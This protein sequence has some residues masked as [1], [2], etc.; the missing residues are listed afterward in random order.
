MTVNVRVLHVFSE[1]TRR[2]ACREFVWLGLHT[3]FWSF[4]LISR[5]SGNSS[6]FQGCISVFLDWRTSLVTHAYGPQKLSFQGSRWMGPWQSVSSWAL[7]SGIQVDL[8]MIRFWVCAKIWGKY[9]AGWF[10]VIFTAEAKWLQGKD[11]RI[12]RWGMW[13]GNVSCSAVTRLLL[14]S[15]FLLK[16]GKKLLL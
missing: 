1:Q 6:N 4:H 5:A 10:P 7:G 16:T 14:L 12:E 8:S 11:L 3:G 2:N 9:L 15:L 13:L